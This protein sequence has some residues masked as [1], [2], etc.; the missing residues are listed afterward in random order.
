MVDPNTRQ[1]KRTP[2]T[3]KIKFKSETLDQFIERY[4]VDVSQGGIFIRTKEPLA[5][6]TQMKFEFQLRDAS[7]LIAGEG[8]VVWTRENDPSR[9]AIAPGMGV[10]FDRL[11]DG[12]QGILERILT[13]K[14]K[15]APQ[16][17]ASD[18]AKP[19]LF[20]DAP[21][22]VAPAPIQEALLGKDYGR[23]R[24]TEDAHGESHTPLPKPMPF[25]SDADEFPDEAFEE[26]TKVR[27]L[28]ELIAQTAESDN[29]S[30]PPTQVRGEPPT[31]VRPDPRGEARTEPRAENTSRGRVNGRNDT[32]LADPV[33]DRAEQIRPTVLP[34]HAEPQ[35]VPDLPNP[36]EFARPQPRLDTPPRMDSLPPSLPDALA[37]T[38]LGVEPARARVSPS[39]PPPPMAPMLGEIPPVPSG[40]RAVAH[41]QTEP[42]RMPELKSRSIAPLVILIFLA[43]AAAGAAV[44]F[45]VL[46]AQI[47]ES[48]DRGTATPPGG[49]AGSA[50]PTSVAGAGAAHPAAPAQP[51]PPTGGE[52]TGAPPAPAGSAAPAETGAAKAELVETEIAASVDGASVEITGTDQKGPAPFT[53]KLEK[54]KPYK[55]RITARG[56]AAT[57]IDIQGGAPKQNLKLVAKPRFLKVSSDPPG[58]QIL[59]DGTAIGKTT[60]SEIELTAAQ[61]AK[62]SIRVGLRKPGFRG[63]ERTIDFAKYVDGDTQMTARVD[64]KLT[65]PPPAPRTPVGAARPP[66][67]GSD[68]GSGAGS[69]SAA[70]PGGGTPAGGSG[71]GST[72]APPPPP[73]PPA[74]PS[75]TGSTAGSAEPEPEFNKPK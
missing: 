61:A 13:E 73:T 36:P 5:V 31:L 69:D 63:L 64:E 22:R 8:T 53:A 75:G 41:E 49:S 28:D 47:S 45:L 46:R 43:V 23:G 48:R 37:R 55:A 33:P 32:T 57:E 72:A 1:G 59:I 65:T 50:S 9:P 51:P 67:P 52:A 34:L 38:R 30:E 58:A 4:A 12:S 19:P 10:R 27:A 29:R 56:F 66:S 2:V 26:A 74:P 24:R 16:R 17:P 6:G 60:P 11:A 3:L 71:D 15:Q 7:P 42:A 54:G 68:T 39:T 14:A 62:K 35:E 44:W 25:H 21:T 70:T 20:T 18:T 40:M